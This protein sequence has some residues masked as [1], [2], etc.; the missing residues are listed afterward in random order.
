MT[1]LAFWLLLGI[2]GAIL[3]AF[4]MQTHTQ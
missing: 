1:E 2:L 4:A 3:A